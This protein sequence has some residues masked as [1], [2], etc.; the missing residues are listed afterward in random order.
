MFH[1]LAPRLDI[2]RVHHLI[3]C[4]GCDLRVQLHLALSYPCSLILI[5]ILILPVSRAPVS[6]M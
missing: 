3:F 6:C 2:T 4:T 1:V 5:L